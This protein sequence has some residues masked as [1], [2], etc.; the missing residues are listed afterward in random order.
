MIV[1][2]AMRK[3]LADEHFVTLMRAEGL[4]TMPRYLADKIA[5][6]GGGTRK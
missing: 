2:S 5:P 3:L 1:V 6:S 4:E